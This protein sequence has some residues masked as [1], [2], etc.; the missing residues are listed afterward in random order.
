V[1]GLLEDP[2]RARRIGREAQE[3]VRDEFLAVRS[4]IQYVELTRRVLR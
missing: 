3:R 1:R 2:D 4:L